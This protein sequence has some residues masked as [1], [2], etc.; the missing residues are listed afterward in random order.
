MKT[1]LLQIL[2]DRAFYMALLSAVL[3]YL[4]QAGI[5]PGELAI[6]LAGLAG[7]SYV[8]AERREKKVLRRQLARHQDGWNH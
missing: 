7:G 5:I 2:K 8:A 1:I 3:T 4:G 6:S